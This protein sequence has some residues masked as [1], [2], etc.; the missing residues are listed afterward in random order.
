MNSDNNAT[1]TNGRNEI[2]GAADGKELNKSTYY[3]NK[4]K[5]DPANRGNREEGS[6]KDINDPFYGTGSDPRN[7]PAEEKGKDDEITGFDHKDYDAKNNS[8]GSHSSTQKQ[9]D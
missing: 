8:A 5:Y 2:T 4:E 3:R 9:E 7:I 1:E 6:P